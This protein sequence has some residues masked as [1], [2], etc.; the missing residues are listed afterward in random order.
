[1]LTAFCFALAACQATADPPVAEWSVEPQSGG[2]EPSYVGSGSRSEGLSLTR[3]A[4]AG[5]LAVLGTGRFV[6]AD[7]T[8]S[9][10]HPDAAGES[11]VSLNLVNL[12]IAEA[13]KVVL[14][15]IFGVDYV[16][17]AALAGKITVHTAH[18]VSKTAALELFQSAL[19]VG[20]AAVVR[21]D[22]LY[23]VV[24]L[25][26]A[27][28]AGGAVSTTAVDR[29]S[30]SIGEN[31]RVVQL[32]YVSASEMKRV[33]EPM[34]VHGG[35][36]RADD[37]RRTLTLS[38]T[39]QDL[40]TL[41]DVI[42]MFDVDTMR[43]MSFALVPV[44]SAD[45]DVLAEDLRHVFGTDDKDGPMSGQVRFIGN[46]RLA[47]ILVI[48]AQP[49]YLSRARAWI[50]RLDA[51]A[52]GTEKQFFTY[53]V[54]NR[55]AKELLEVLSSMFGGN[56]AG[57]GANNGAPRFG[58]SSL[59]SGGDSGPFGPSSAPPTS[60][61]GALSSSGPT[62]GPGGPG[63]TPGFFGSSGAGSGGSGFGA[64]IG[65]PNDQ[66][67]SKGPQ[68][69]ALGE[70]NRFKLGVDDAK[71]ALVIMA[72]PDDYK[73]IRR[74]IEALDVAPNQVF[75]EATIA[76][77]SLTDEL[78]FGVAWFLQKGAN[79]GAFSGQI[80]GPNNVPTIPNSVLGNNLLGA[81]VGAAFPGF[82]YA[83]RASSVLATLN[84]LN[85]IT[86]VNILST[87]SLTV[88]DNRQ[89][90]LQVG[91]QI[92]VTTLQS[93]A[94]LGNTFNSVSYLNTGVI[95]AITP[96]ISESGR[97]MLDI[98]QE[99]SNAV[100]GTGL[101]GNNPTIQQRKVKTQV[102]VADGESLMLGGL[103]Q[104]SRSRNANQIPVAGDLPIIGN[105]FKDKDD[106][107]DKKELIIMITPHVVRS[108]SEAREIAEEYKRKMLNVASKAVARPHDI[109][110][111]TRRTLLDDT[112]V[113]PWVL[114][115]ASR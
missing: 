50:E 57:H 70:D 42:T 82:A 29:T 101:G 59:S 77:V 69:A 14:G 86:N 10:I 94:P 35:I 53:R 52:Q 103:I 87:P 5:G 85:A 73:R 24:P 22:E 21:S 76:E 91:D 110:Q 58:Q 109:E 66:P 23:K 65:G 99:V 40:A 9:K 81:P 12:P 3:S 78:H 19:R 15:D 113:S 106:T 2:R 89:A 60:P 46:K 16:V 33:L 108:L 56:G 8:T 72:T 38:G 93:V 71:N 88:L 1:L 111:S 49:Q 64:N 102:A 80:A 44:K 90:V 30:L 27:A 7:R 51:R 6:G 95:L 79:A 34:T 11:A 63:G 61:L 4:G 75:I 68:A 31:T 67:Q 100:P 98:D 104:D 39:Q 115:R 47:A 28:T 112:S 114:D 55:P 105:A 32:R 92:P 107:I 74:V 36:V 26:Q 20:G 62:S 41:E 48:S 97:L 17:D 54:Q 96:H 13:T 83:V 43:G 45:A 37:A 84:A 18:P 25:D